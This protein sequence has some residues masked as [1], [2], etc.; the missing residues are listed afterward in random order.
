MIHS[1]KIPLSPSNYAV[2]HKHFSPPAGG[3]HYQCFI[4]LATLTSL[5][6]MFAQHMPFPANF[7]KSTLLVWTLDYVPICILF[8]K[9]S[10]KDR[11]ELCQA[12]ADF[13]ST[14][15]FFL[16]K[17]QLPSYDL[18]LF[19]NTLCSQPSRPQRKLQEKKKRSRKLWDWSVVPPSVHTKFRTSATFLQRSW[20]STLV[21]ILGPAGGSSN[22]LGIREPFWKPL[23][24][25]G[26]LLFAGLLLPWTQRSSWRIFIFQRDGYHRRKWRGTLG[27]PWMPWRA[28]GVAGRGGNR[29][30]GPEHGGQWGS[31]STPLESTEH[32]GGVLQCAEGGVKSRWRGKRGGSWGAGWG[33]KAL[34][35]AFPCTPQAA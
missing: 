6:G 4:D 35:R 27:K 32:A 28:E 9:S 34:G 11:R 12:I 21:H 16:I 15:F 8:R 7:R 30:R 3:L 26:D 17:W 33:W 18:S 29:D 31:G 13:L 20:I 14:F 23:E 22:L 24:R 10:K 1:D 19:R 25:P 5:Q 2:Y